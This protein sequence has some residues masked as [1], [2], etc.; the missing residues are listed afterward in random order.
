LFVDARVNNWVTANVSLLYSSLTAI[1]GSQGFYGITNTQL[2]FHPIPVA[3]NIDTAYATIGNL[4]ASPFYFRVGKE[5]VPFDQYDPY[6][7]VQS[8][9]PTQLLSETNAVTAQLGFVTANGFY[10]SLYTFSG[11]P[12]LS[13]AGS[14]RRIQNGGGDLGYKLT[15]L[16]GKVNVNAGYIA[17]IADSNFLSAY[18]RNS[19]VEVM[20]PTGLPNQ[21]TPA[22]NI[23][24]E[25][26]FGPFD[27]NAHYVAATRNLMSPIFL[28]LVL[29]PP[30]PPALL[31]FPT[32][33]AKAWGVE[34]GLTFPVMAHQSRLA[35]GYQQTNH[36][37]TLLPKRRVYADYMVNFTQW[38]DMGI[39][40]FQDRDYS[41]GEGAVVVLP[42]TPNFPS[43]LFFSSGA[44]GNKSTVGQL[45]ASI[46]FA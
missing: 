26:Q 23:N 3:S 1:S 30:P 12:K 32:G 7:F 4:Q 24:A 25:V 44:T 11:N 28:E 38:F 22:Y 37:A 18:Y 41:S 46:K 31:S 39:A 20:N 33:K 13:D 45:R 42:N 34:A 17:N 21:K 9:N 43:E 40:L 14:A 10:G 2:L 29:D 16:S 8:E 27:A 36:L 19:L 35:I 15:L 5:Y 6:E